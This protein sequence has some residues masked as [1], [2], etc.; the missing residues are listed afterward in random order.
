M[1]RNYFSWAGG[2]TPSKAAAP[3]PEAGAPAAA[4]DAKAEPKKAEA[5]DE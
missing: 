4:P 3:A 2:K 5:K 1:M